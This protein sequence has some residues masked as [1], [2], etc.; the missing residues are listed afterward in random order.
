MR[1]RF[2]KHWSILLTFKQLM[3]GK[4]CRPCLFWMRRA[5][6]R[7]PVGARRLASVTSWRI[8]CEGLLLI[9]QGRCRLLFPIVRKAVHLVTHV[10]HGKGI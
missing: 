1:F 2:P 9:F 4:L 7:F 10:N 3:I 5:R 8:P 6:R